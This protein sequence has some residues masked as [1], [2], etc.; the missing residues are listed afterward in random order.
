LKEKETN[1]DSYRDKA[2]PCLT[3]SAGRKSPIGK[4][5]YLKGSKC[6][7]LLRAITGFLKAL[8]FSLPVFG[9]L[10]HTFSEK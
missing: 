1:P 10:E 4:F 5:I 6:G 2:I 7:T 9:C 8:Y 3:A